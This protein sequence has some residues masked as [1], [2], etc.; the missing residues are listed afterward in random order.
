MVLSFSCG[1]TSFTVALAVF[2]CSGGS[3]WGSDPTSEFL[4]EAQPHWQRYVAFERT[5]VY[6]ATSS[7]NGVNTVAGR[8]DVTILKRNGECF[9]FV[10]ESTLVAADGKTQY[11]GGEVTGRNP[12]Y[13]FTL[14]RKT[15]EGP[16][17]IIKLEKAD[18]PQGT[19]GEG[20]GFLMVVDNHGLSMPSLAKKPGFRVLSCSRAPGEVVIQFEWKPQG[21]QDY[22][23]EG[24]IV[25]DPDQ[26]WCVRSAETRALSR[27]QVI[28][29]TSLK[30]E[31][32]PNQGLPLARSRYVKRWL[33]FANNPKPEESETNLTIAQVVPN[34][35]PPITDFTLSAFGLPEPPGV[36]W[37]RPTP[38]Y[39]W[40]GGIAIICLIVGFLFKRF[41]WRTSAAA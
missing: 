30:H 33:L 12:K 25:L 17:K 38:W 29:K 18:P 23:V 34:P 41:A 15:S 22:Q 9:L 11:S 5:L 19:E 20:A 24:R 35:L 6:S 2:L 14:S 39:L 27:G 36:T 1:K 32:E 8:K 21:K 16:W 26:C 31:Y 7:M 4:Q 28:N 10:G 3:L 13:S 40:A 37:E